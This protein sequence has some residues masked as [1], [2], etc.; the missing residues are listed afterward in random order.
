M[1]ARNQLLGMAKNQGADGRAPE[2]PGRYAAVQ[3]HTDQQKATA[4]GLTVA[5]VNKV[6]STAGAAPT[7]TTSSTAAASRKCICRASPIRA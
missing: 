7:S 6:L 5:D 3:D 2:R 4:L 1:A